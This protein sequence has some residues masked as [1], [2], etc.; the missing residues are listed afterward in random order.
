MY[1]SWKNH[2]RDK[3]KNGW[4]FH[5]SKSSRIYSNRRVRHG[6]NSALIVGQEEAVE[7]AE[8]AEAV[9]RAHDYWNI[10]D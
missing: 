10:F 8:N 4:R 7:A 2:L 5:Q 1:Q 9:K 3:S 6:I